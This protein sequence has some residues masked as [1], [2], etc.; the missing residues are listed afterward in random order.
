MLSHILGDPRQEMD[1]ED[2]RQMRYLEM[3]IKETLRLY[4]SIQMVG[5][6]L[7]ESLTL[8]NGNI[9]P[10]N[11]TCYVPILSI[12]QDPDIYPNPKQFNPERFAPE[13]LLST[14]ISPYAYIPF[15]AGPRNCIGQKYAMLE[16]K[17]VLADL[18]RHFR[19][20]SLTDPKEIVKELTPV[21][22]P[23]TK[24]KVLFEPI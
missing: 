7:T 15:S 13:N 19:V 20:T 22:K 14:G 24:I 9:I 21:I 11:S 3:C 1:M 17:Y 10:A 8:P 16:L 23:L 5:R 2:L 12:H 4:P 18:F 6:Q